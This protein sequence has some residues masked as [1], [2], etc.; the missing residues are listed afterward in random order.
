MKEGTIFECSMPSCH[1]PFRVAGIMSTVLLRLKQGGSARACPWSS[2]SGSSFPVQG[3]ILEFLTAHS[4]L[5]VLYLHQ[6]ERYVHLAS[7]S[8]S[9]RSSHVNP[10]AKPVSEHAASGPIADRAQLA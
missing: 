2:H 1:L 10:R 3:Q 9:G 5:L 4:L 6:P 8:T 7:L